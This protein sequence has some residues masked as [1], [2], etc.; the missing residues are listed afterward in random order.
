[1]FGE[2][3]NGEIWGLGGGGDGREESRGGGRRDDR[4]Q[5]TDGTYKAC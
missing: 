1:V 4:G 3:R 5:M 2:S